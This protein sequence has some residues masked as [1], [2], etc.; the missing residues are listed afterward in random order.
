MH[1]ADGQRPVCPKLW[2]LDI[3]FL[4]VIIKVWLYDRGCGRTWAN[5]ELWGGWGVV[6][7]QIHTSSSGVPEKKFPD[8][9]LH[10]AYAGPYLMNTQGLSLVIPEYGRYDVLFYIVVGNRIQKVADWFLF[11]QWRYDSSTITAKY[12]FCVVLLHFFYIQPRV[13]QHLFSPPGPVIF[14]PVLNLWSCYCTD[15]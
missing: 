10:I 5:G 7:T 1:W 9:C 6:E 11:C 14:I 3:Y 15:S 12:D 2:A 8:H 13:P 4:H